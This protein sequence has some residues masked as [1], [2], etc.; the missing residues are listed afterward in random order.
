MLRLRRDGGIGKAEAAEV[1]IVNSHDGTSAY[2][3]VFGKQHDRLQLLDA[4]YAAAHTKSMVRRNISDCDEKR[5]AQL[6]RQAGGRLRAM[7]FST[8]SSIPTAAIT[9]PSSVVIEALLK[10]P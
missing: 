8:T 6:G 3:L 10:T 5:E 4:T 1:I 2:Q 7:I 9:K